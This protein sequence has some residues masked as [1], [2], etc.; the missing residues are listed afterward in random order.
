MLKI[1]PEL[2]ILGEAKNASEAKHLIDRLQPDFIFLDIQMPGASGFELLQN[3]TKPPQVIFVTAYDKFAI[4]A[5]EHNALDYLLKPISEDRLQKSITRIKQTM[6]QALGKD[7]DFLKHIFLP[8]S[9]QYQIIRTADICHIQSIGNY[10]QIHTM[11]QKG[12]VKTSLNLLEQQ[13]DPKAFF[14]INR[15]TIINIQHIEKI[16]LEEKILKVILKNEMEFQMSE[17]KTI[18]FKRNIKISI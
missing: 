6:Q 10:A 5:F 11:D 16:W 14:R 15:S 4:P 17:R 8:D 18:E 1:Y 12:L 2:E 3:L 13:L 7:R 9:K